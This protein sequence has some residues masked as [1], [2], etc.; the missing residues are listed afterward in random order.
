[1]HEEGRAQIAALTE[2]RDDTRAKLAFWE[3]AFP[4]PQDALER[5]EQLEAERNRLA[6]EVLAAEA[7]RCPERDMNGECVELNTAITRAEAAEAKVAR[8]EALIADWGHR[9]AWHP[10]TAIRAALQG[11]PDA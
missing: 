6:A 10:V 7:E 2:E 8:V 11:E 5:I 3:S 9:A 4:T 1:V